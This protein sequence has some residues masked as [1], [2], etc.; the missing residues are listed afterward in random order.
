MEHT[1]DK[2][3]GKK[4][5]SK[6]KSPKT[7]K[8]NIKKIQTHGIIFN[9]LGT[10]I[11]DGFNCSLSWYKDIGVMVETKQFDKIIKRIVLWTCINY[12]E[13]E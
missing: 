11:A 6:T 1:T 8:L 7:N 10:I 13:V 12:I 9:N 5:E 2:V 3:S 4:V